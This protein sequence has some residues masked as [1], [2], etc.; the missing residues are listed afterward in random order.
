M[1][2]DHVAFGGTFRVRMRFAELRSV[3]VRG[4]ALVLT[5]GRGALE[6]D[7]GPAQAKAWEGQIARPKP[8]LD[9]LG[10]K[11]GSRVAVLG[12]EDE[13][14]LAALGERTGEVVLGRTRVRCDLIFFEAD[15]RRDLGRL[16][17]LR[18]ALQPAGAIWPGEPPG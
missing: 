6:L 3:D 16:A 17:T 2:T 14:F 11:P 1:E 8:L 18:R 13:D 4:G 9:K 15:G 5:S 10:V 12:V 7:L